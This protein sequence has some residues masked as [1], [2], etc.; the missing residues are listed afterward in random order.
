MSSY[1]SSLAPATTHQSPTICPQCGSANLHVETRPPHRALICSRGHWIKWVNKHDAERYASTPPK[2]KPQLA[3]VKPDTVKPGTIEQRL[4]RLE[5][6]LAYI[7]QLFIHHVR[8][9]GSEGA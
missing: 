6:D 9:H 1:T 8:S 3:L 2:P 5:K 7:C 4:D